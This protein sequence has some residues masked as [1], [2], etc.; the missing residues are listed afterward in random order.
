VRKSAEPSEESTAEDRTPRT[1]GENTNLV[2][3][4]ARAE[5]AVVAR[6]HAALGRTDYP[7][8]LTLAAEHERRWP[9]GMFEVEREG[10][11]AIAA[12]GARASDAAAR[13]ARF[14]A[15]NP[16]APVAMRVRSACSAQ[17][18]ARQAR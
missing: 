4:D 8:A 16:H 11:R 9:H 12:C 5:L 2:P 1:V 7:T 14:L 3:D 13:A 18:S 6:M 17:L 15:N 10:V